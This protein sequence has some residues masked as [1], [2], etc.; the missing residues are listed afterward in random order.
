[1]KQVKVSPVVYQMILELSK[2]ERKSPEN[3]LGDL[4]TITYAKK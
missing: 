1:M 3:Y 2:S 4:I